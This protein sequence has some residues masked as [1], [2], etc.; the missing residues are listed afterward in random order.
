MTVSTPTT[1][2]QVLTSA[3]VN[4]NINSGL[5]Y[6][7]EQ[8]IGSAVSS[9]SVTSAFSTTYDN[10][11]IT[12]SGTA[13]S[14][15]DS[16]AFITLNGSAGS[17]YSYAGNFMAYTSGTVNGNNAS[18]GTTGFWLGLTGGTFSAS[19]DVMN[20]F[21]AKATNLF[22]QSSGS[23]HINT[24]LGYDSNAAS[25]TGFTISQLTTNLTGGII[26]VFGYRKA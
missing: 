7:K 15:T 6:I 5:V 13:V 22:G 26:T 10:Y 19:F 8:T 3:Y 16:S 9:V 2:G 24:F 23:K 14:A 1:S 12:V 4:N 18:A 25:S 17:T 11:L 20:P 21:L